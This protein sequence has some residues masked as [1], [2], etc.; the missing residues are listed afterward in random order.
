MIRREKLLHKQRQFQSKTHTNNCNVH[1]TVIL[2]Q[3]KGL[4]IG[5]RLFVGKR[6]RAGLL[7]LCVAHLLAKLV[8]DE[9]GAMQFELGEFALRLGLGDL[10][11]EQLLAQGVEFTARRR[12][13]LDGRA[14]ILATALV[15]RRRQRSATAIFVHR[16]VEFGAVHL[17]LVHRRRGV[18][19]FT[20]GAEGVHVR[21]D[22]RRL[23]VAR[24]V[25]EA[26]LG[27]GN[28]DERGWSD[29]RA[30]SSRRDRLIEQSAF[31]SLDGLHSIAVNTAR[32]SMSAIGL[33]ESRDHYF[34]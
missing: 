8:D 16:F 3:R 2:L 26:V 14:R 7:H 6:Q 12:R 27:G 11:S 19:T 15:R 5:K 33:V 22:S 34:G 1:D 21:V 23:P 18:D 13:R 25:D 31:S 29:G 9:F 10:G 24:R 17:L 30:D 32:N 20:V 28:G 4:F